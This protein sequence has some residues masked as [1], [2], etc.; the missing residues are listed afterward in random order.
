MVVRAAPTPIDL[1]ST[2]NPSTASSCMRRT[3]GA[4]FELTVDTRRYS[5]Y[6]LDGIERLL[7]DVRSALYSD[8]ARAAIHQLRRFP[9]SSHARRFPVGI[10]APDRISR[11]AADSVQET[12]FSRDRRVWGFQRRRPTSPC[13]LRHY[14]DSRASAF[15]AEFVTSPARRAASFSIRT[16]NPS[17]LTPHDCS[18]P[19]A[20]AAR[21]TSTTPA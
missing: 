16:T 20:Q 2:C 6:P 10:S 21:R 13:R 11:A 8:A 4:R 9:V 1:E 18:L 3:A 19:H 12:A 5:L 7:R 14:Y 15:R 17:R